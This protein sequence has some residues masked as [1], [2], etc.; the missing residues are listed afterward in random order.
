MKEKINKEYKNNIMIKVIEKGTFYICAL[1][2]VMQFAP[3]KVSAKIAPTQWKKIYKITQNDNYY[4]SINVDYGVAPISLEHNS[5]GMLF[6]YDSSGT[7]TYWDN[8]RTDMYDLTTAY[9]LQVLGNT[10]DIEDKEVLTLTAHKAMT[11]FETK[12]VAVFY[13]KQNNELARVTQANSSDREWVDFIP[14]NP[15]EN[16]YSVAFFLED[17]NVAYVNNALQIGVSSFAD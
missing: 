17:G 2:L 3:V 5:V 6:A 11:N 8:S 16:V 9:H 14:D 12:Y 15:I 1:L 13:D 4:A 10:S 7:Y